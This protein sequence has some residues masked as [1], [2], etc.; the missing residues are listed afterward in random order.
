MYLTASDENSDFK[1]GFYACVLALG[2]GVMLNVQ[3]KFLRPQDSGKNRALLDV[4]TACI[5]RY[6]SVTISAVF[7]KM[8]EGRPQTSHMC[9]E[10]C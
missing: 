9:L 1:N 2:V 5:Y 10:R 7:P 8:P 6:A 4:I 3:K